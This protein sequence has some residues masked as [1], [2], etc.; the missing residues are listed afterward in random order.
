VVDVACV[1][2]FHRLSNWHCWLLNPG[3]D[4]CSS[5]LD[6]ISMELL[7]VVAVA[8]NDVAVVVMDLVVFVAVEEDDEDECC[9]CCWDEK[10]VFH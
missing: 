7:L 4:Y 8:G 2:A 6:G 3:K 1:V 9:Y 5:C 10:L